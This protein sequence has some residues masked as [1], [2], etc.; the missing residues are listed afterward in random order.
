MSDASLG[1]IAPAS[2]SCCVNASSAAAAAK[3]V[4]GT[5]VD[6]EDDG[7][8]EAV[9]TGPVGLAPAVRS[10]PARRAAVP[11]ASS[12]RAPAIHA[13]AGHH[14]LRRRS[15]P[16]ARRGRTAVAVTGTTGQWYEFDVTAYLQA[17]KALGHNTVTLVLKNPTQQNALVV[18]NSDDAATN[19]PQLA[20]T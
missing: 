9:D 19:Q 5:T 13:A 2:C 12:A 1:S 18:F 7:D 17:E 16:F 15:S 6:G 20:I 14:G 11:I 3:G 10:P 4:R 8:D